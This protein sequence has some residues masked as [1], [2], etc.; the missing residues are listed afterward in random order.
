[1]RE[2]LPKELDFTNEAR[3]ARKAVKNFENINTSLYIPEV[4]SADKR[5]LIMEFIE[6]ARV[7]DLEYLAAHNIDRNTVSLELSRIFSQMVYVDGWFH[8]DPHP[9]NLFIRQRPAISRSPYN[10][11]IVLLDHGLYFDL[12]RSLRINYSKLWLSLIAPAGPEN[13]ANRR[14]YAQLVGNIDS[15]QYP[16]FEAALTGRASMEDTPVDPRPEKESQSTFK[17]ASSM[18]DQLPQTEEEVEALRN[19]VMTREGLLLSVFDILR[20]VPRRVLMVFMLNDLT[21]S[22]DHALSTTHSE[23]RVFVVVAKYCATAVWEDERQ[24]IFDDMRGS[25]LLSP[26]RLARYF[27][28]WWRY[29]KLYCGL[30]VLEWYMDTQA[31]ARKFTAW[32]GGLCRTGFEGAHKAAAGLT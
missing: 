4:I 29:E 13:N 2:N 20:K 19:A 26:R 28:A 14:K 22:L 31:Q 7:D 23:V 25:G 11:E 5:V 12:D 30:V 6:G 3:N 15:V 17:R 8:A 16:I 32:F 27:T 1:M 9:G 21:R 24:A 18:L 10:F